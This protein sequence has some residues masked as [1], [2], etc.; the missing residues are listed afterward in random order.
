MY[1]WKFKCFSVNILVSGRY[2]IREQHS[3]L[4]VFLDNT[5]P[6]DL[7]SRWHT[8]R[9]SISWHSKR[10]QHPE[11]NIIIGYTLL[12]ATNY[13]MV[14]NFCCPQQANHISIWQYLTAIAWVNQGNRVNTNE[15]TGQWCRAEISSYPG[16]V[17]RGK[18]GLVST[19]CACANDSRNFPRTRSEYGQ[20]THGCYAEK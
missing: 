9:L 5:N 3:L 18:S 12:Q 13:C 19:V 14:C 11:R 6:L 7:R 17:V 1:Y 2:L 8:Q 20:V 4:P 10:T 15:L 16:H